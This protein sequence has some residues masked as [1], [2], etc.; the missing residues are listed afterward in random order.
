M[1]QVRNDNSKPAPTRIAAESD[2]GKREGLVSTQWTGKRLKPRKSLVEQA[3]ADLRAAIRAGAFGMDGQLPS[4]PT[5]SAQLGVSRPT[6]RQ[7]LSLL[8]QEGLV[9]RKQGMGTFVQQAV[10]ALPDLLNANTGI[11]GMIQS[12]GRAPETIKTV[13]R[14]TA[15]DERIAKQLRIDS[16]ST[17][18]VI[19]RTR[20]A[21]GQIV[22]FTR[23]MVSTSL[24]KSHGVEAD[25][26][27]DLITR[28]SSLYLA[29]A[30]F[31]LNVTYGIAHV[32]PV[33][34]SAHLQQTLEVAAETLLI[35]LEQTDY[36]EASNPVIFAEEYLIP[37][38][39]AIY[40]LRRGPG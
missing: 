20:T 5:L 12:A 3:Q 35:L 33:L 22:A 4:E 10:A 32:L 18:V 15:A 7:A 25:K 27:D 19:E 16:G 6:I 36:D 9:V 17:V 31:G 2:Q 40:V 39:L 26:I 23:D 8:E 28:D 38:P 29:L 24:L 1:K 21:D 11:T 37:G 13:V 34:A 30:D 14:L